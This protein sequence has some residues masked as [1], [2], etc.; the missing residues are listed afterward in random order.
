MP[1]HT[2]KT[3]RNNEEIKVSQHTLF[4]FLVQLFIYTHE[5]YTQKKISSEQLSSKLWNIKVYKIRCTPKLWFWAKN[6][7]RWYSLIKYATHWFFISSKNECTFLNVNMFVL[8]S[9]SKTPHIYTTMK[10]QDAH[11]PV[12][13]G[14][15][16]FL[17]HSI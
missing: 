16:Q 7:N 13:F 14:L 11:S 9:C 5:T 12:I 17:H 10:F 3:I 1:Y 8:C 6:L 4:S 2:G 15:L